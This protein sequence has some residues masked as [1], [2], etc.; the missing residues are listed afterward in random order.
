MTK[1]LGKAL[2]ANIVYPGAG[3]LFL[4]KWIRAGVFS[5]CALGVVVWVFWAFIACIIGNYY[6]VADGGDIEFNIINLILPFIAIFILWVY[7]YIDL[8]FFCKI[9]DPGAKED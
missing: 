1:Q 4:K 9:P 7:S 3:Q 5:I 8:F 6:S 2:M